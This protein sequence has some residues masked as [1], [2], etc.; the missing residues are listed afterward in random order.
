MYAS[1]RDL[2]EIKDLTL[3][4][5]TLLGSLNANIVQES[6]AG[7]Y[8]INA[9]EVL[10]LWI[11]HNLMHKGTYRNINYS[12]SIDYKNEENQK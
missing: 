9:S 8:P 2:Y 3:L 12:I 5:L 4:D 6:Q 7:L 10:K 1:A 11:F